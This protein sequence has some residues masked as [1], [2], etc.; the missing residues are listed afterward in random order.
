MHQELYTDPKVADAQTL[1]KALEPRSS[2]LVSLETNLVDAVWGQERPARPKSKVFHLDVKYSGR[3]PSHRAIPGFYILSQESRI[4]IR[5]LD[6]EKSSPRKTQ[7]LWLSL[8]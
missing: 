1:T 6:S 8:C 2:E 7:K 4:W 5:S 3:Q